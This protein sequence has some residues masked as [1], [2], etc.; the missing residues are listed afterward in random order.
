MSDVA[1]RYSWISR[2]RPKRVTVDLSWAYPDDWPFAYIGSLK[3][4]FP[5]SK[6]QYA[7]TPFDVKGMRTLIELG[8]KFAEGATGGVLSAAG[9]SSRLSRAAQ[10][11]AGKAYETTVKHVE[12]LE[13]ALSDPEFMAFLAASATTEA[14]SGGTATPITGAAALLATYRYYKRKKARDLAK[15]K[16]RGSSAREA[17]RQEEVSD[18]ASPFPWIPSRAEFQALKQVAPSRLA[19][20]EVDRIIDLHLQ[21]NAL[22][23]YGSLVE[24]GSPETRD[25]LGRA[26]AIAKSNL[27]KYGY[28]SDG[29]ATRK[30]ISKA[31]EKLRDPEAWDKL[32]AYEE[33]LASFRKG[34]RRRS[35]KGRTDL[36]RAMLREQ[37]AAARTQAAEETEGEVAARVLAQMGVRV[38]RQTPRQAPRSQKKQGVDLEGLARRFA[39]LAQAKKAK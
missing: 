34:P 38:P 30:G 23:V 22:G 18:Q 9:S 6:D 5:K 33:L 24:R 4:R 13:D 15:K 31:V 37:L 3:V 39:A 26:F 8:Q 32:V 17:V 36:Q 28:L 25:T 19:N 7:R 35:T 1:A 14:A 27:E 2:V 20:E 10:W 16:K 29:F 21:R 12:G 11:T